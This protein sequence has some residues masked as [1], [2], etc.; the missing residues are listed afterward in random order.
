[1]SYNGVPCAR[2]IEAWMEGVSLEG[3][4]HN[5]LVDLANHL[6]YVIGKNPVRSRKIVG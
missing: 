2:I 1:M 5:T 3:N 6:R 4:R